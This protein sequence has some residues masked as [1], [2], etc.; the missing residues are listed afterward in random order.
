MRTLNI[1]VCGSDEPAMKRIATALS[2]DGVNIE[3]SSQPV[4]NLISVRQGW[5]F[6]LVDLDGLDSFLRTLLPSI[7]CHFPNL[8]VIGVSTKSS[9][10]DTIDLGRV[11]RL[12]GCLDRLPRPED[13]IVSSPQ[14]AAKYLCDTKPLA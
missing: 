7:T 1:L 13:L 12:D 14:V 11:L 2:D 4:N 8:P 6:L 9:R 10:A 5:D 3:T